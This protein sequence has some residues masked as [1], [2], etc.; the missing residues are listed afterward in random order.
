[1]IPQK[2]N[3]TRYGT[4]RDLKDIRHTSNKY[5]EMAQVGRSRVRGQASWTRKQEACDCITR[6]P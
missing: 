4:E 2:S 3:A 6:R 1:M 5:A